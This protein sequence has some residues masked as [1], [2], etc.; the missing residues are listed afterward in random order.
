MYVDDIFNSISTIED[1]TIL[2]DKLDRL[3]R[4]LRKWSSNSEKVLDGIPTHLRAEDAHISQPTCMSHHSCRSGLGLYW[5]TE[6]D[7]LKYK[8]AAEIES[9]LLP[10]TKRNFPTICPLRFVNPFF[11]PAK[12]LF[13]NL[14]IRGLDRDDRV[15][16]DSSGQYG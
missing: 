7:Y 12:I 2:Q 11:I 16:A 15:S 3:F 8:L 1:A 6:E 9:S 5:N 14:W 13:Q 10:W 4:T